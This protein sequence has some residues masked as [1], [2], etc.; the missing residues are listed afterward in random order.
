MAKLCTKCDTIRPPADFAAGTGKDGLQAWCRACMSVYRKGRYVSRPGPH[1]NTRPRAL[2]TETRAW[3]IA[4]KALAGCA[5][6]GETDVT[7]LDLHHR[8]RATKAFAF[9]TTGSHRPLAEVQAE[10]E[11]C[12]VLCKN[13]H[14]KL[15]AGRFALEDEEASA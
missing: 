14:A 10:A 7:C 9:G 5:R 13:C 15:H 6:C 4:W 2:L 11:K 1:G 3:V 8:D 12:V